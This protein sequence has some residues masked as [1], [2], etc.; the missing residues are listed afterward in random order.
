[1]LYYRKI[2]FYTLEEASALEIYKKHNDKSLAS[3]VSVYSES[4]K[5]IL[6]KSGIINHKKIFVNGIPR[7]DYSFRLRK[8]KPKGKLIVYYMI[9]ADRNSK[10]LIKNKNINSKK[11]YNQTLEYIVLQK[12]P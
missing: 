5:K 11:L 8:I 2:D 10:K 4:Q 7:C 1:M 12:E 6:I 9:E 3:K